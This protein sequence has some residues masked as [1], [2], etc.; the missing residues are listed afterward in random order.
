MVEGALHGVAALHDL[1]IQTGA[2]VEQFSALVSVGKLTGTT[3]DEIAGMMNKLAK[4]MAVANEESKGTGQAI[5]A[6]GLNFN[7][8]NA[9][10]PD[11]KLVTLAGAMNGF[12]DGSDKS[13]VAMTLLGKSGA[14]ALPFLQ[15]LADVGELHAKVTEEQATQARQ[16]EVDMKRLQVSGDAWK[17]ELSLGMLPA[18]Q[19]AATATLGMVND[20]GG[21]REE[22]KKLSADGSIADWTRTAIVGA[23][24]VMDAFSGLKDVIITVGS[25]IGFMAAS[26]MLQF[27]GISTIVNKVIHG[28]FAGAAETYRTTTVA[29]QK[30]TE[31]FHDTL[32][33]TWG[34][35][36]LGQQLR[37]RIANVQAV[38]VAVGEDRAQLD[39][40]SESM[41]KAKEVA[42]QAAKAGTDY[43]RSIQDSNEKLQLEIDLG[44][45]LTPAQD[46][47]LKLTQ[48]L[49]AGK[50]VMSAE[51]E[52]LT[53]A[54]IA[55]GDV[56]ATNYKNQQQDT[57]ENYKS[58]V[59]IQTKID[60]LNDET[61]KT[62]DN[63]DMMFLTK[64]QIVEIKI[65][66]LEEMAV[67]ADH[68][69]QMLEE[70]GLSQDLI[71]AQKN[72][73][74][75]YRG[76]EA[77]A[78]RGAIL[79]NAKDTAAE[80]K[81]TSD[82]I[83]A[84][85]T[86]AFLGAVESGK[87]IFVAFR[88]YLIKMFEQ[89]VLTPTIQAIM[90]PVSNALTGMV[91]GALGITGGGSGSSGAGGM[92]G[93]SSMGSSLMSGASALG[94]MA[95]G[96]MSLANGAG[97]IAANAG[98][99]GGGIDGLLATNGA[100]GTAAAAGATSVGA[101]TLAGAGAETGMT[102]G[103]AAAMDAGY[104]AVAE[105]ASVGGSEI[106]A[107][108]S[109]G[110]LGWVALGISALFSLNGGSDYK[111]HGEEKSTFGPD[112]SVKSGGMGGTL[113]HKGVPSEVEQMYLAEAAKMG[114]AKRA[115]EFDYTEYFNGHIEE[116]SLLVDGNPMDI[117]VLSDPSSLE[118]V[119]AQAALAA[120]T[121]QYPNFENDRS[122]IS[123][124][125]TGG[126]WGGGIRLVGENGPEIEVTGPSRI[127]NA[128]QTAS[129]LR[130]G[131]ADNTE[132]LVEMRLLR[133]AFEQNV[134]N[135]AKTN[136][137]LDRIVPLGDALSVRTVV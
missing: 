78:S 83:G 1:S 67:A 3:G 46:A 72:L 37:D 40:H 8:F 43:A 48:D 6:L 63:N 135:T 115:V 134:A 73:A 113:V 114:V 36:T 16:F 128:D 58:A 91:N 19:E 9:M 26:A 130:S 112:G 52:T 103:S 108:I 29:Q 102:M 39:Y 104:G 55:N 25:S 2:S 82:Q 12:A 117:I 116:A 98:Y 35:S 51:L 93:A 137:T 71:D 121:Q 54:G 23:T 24:Y 22:I 106:A 84:G 59:A 127:F 31:D 34:E 109:A 79:Q 77:E 122:S 129:M 18:L 65:A 74:A 20:T 70:A 85:L 101:G 87:S 47:D 80:W 131:G 90:S 44:H 4:N 100:Y 120:V 17:K 66:R 96:S 45:K 123:G 86:Q 56:L 126:D 88:D 133:R 89:M 111:P 62:R 57:D 28:D 49:A 50:K 119:K 95:T 42:D 75:A 107:G 30:M 14:Q 61:S 27:E 13:A 38:G 64:E 53:R 110:P 76:A 60:K 136:R 125:A 15:E 69:A 11:E 97:S 7:D 94:S 81:K 33:K 41:A 124:M 132:L 92:A 105:G 10:S 21:L 68:Q 5:A 32:D 99:A 118:D